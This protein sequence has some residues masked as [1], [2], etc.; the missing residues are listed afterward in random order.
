M[1]AVYFLA[2]ALNAAALMYW[3]FLRRKSQPVN[4][5]KEVV[6]RCALRRQIHYDYHDTEYFVTQEDIDAGFTRITDKVIQA[7]DISATAYEEV[8]REAEA[9]QEKKREAA[10][11]KERGLERVKV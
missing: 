9:E 4:P 8:R 2:G 11:Q 10:K 5:A 3:L 6:Y 1:E 7:M